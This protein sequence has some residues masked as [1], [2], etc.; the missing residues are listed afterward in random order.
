MKNC[1]FLIVFLIFSSNNIV[2]ANANIVF[3]DMDKILSTTKPGLSIL[4]QL[5]DLNDKNLKYVQNEEKILKNKEKKIIA[6]KNI[7][8]TEEYN[9]RAEKLKLEIN[10]YNENKKKIIINFNKLK[11]DNK[12]KLLKMIN[13]ILTKYSD[14]KSISIILQKKHLIIGK[15]ELDITDEI[16]MII[17][18]DINTFKIK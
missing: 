6:Q 18:N 13:Q 11:I 15:T 14:E 17:N 2:M 9:S 8:S 7:I 4:K 1:F 12:N 5:K 16:I 10:E 3:L